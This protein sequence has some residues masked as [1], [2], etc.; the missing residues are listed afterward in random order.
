MSK[1]I[2]VKDETHIELEGLLR[3]RESFSDVVERL[4]MVYRKQ[5]ELLNVLEGGIRFRERLAQDLEERTAHV[6]ET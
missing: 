5:A 3:P 1:T 4:L 6:K 2:K